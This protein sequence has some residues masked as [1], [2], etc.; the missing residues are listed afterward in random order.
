MTRW[1]YGLTPNEEALACNVGYLR[2]QPYIGS[3]ESNRRFS[4]GDMW[5]I[6]QHT[7]TT[8]SEIAFARMLGMADFSPSVN[9]RKGEPDVG[10][11][12]VRYKFTD[13][14]LKEPSLRFSG[15]VDK[16]TSPYVL[17]TG[18]PEKK[19][20]RSAAN[21]YRTPDFI[22]HGWCYPNEVLRPE[23]ITGE[24]NGK[25]TYSVPISALRSMSEL[26]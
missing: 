24:E 19:I 5:E 14:G 11:W 15:N 10:S 1:N 21:G 22:A 12:E 3:P 18:G 8:M 23:F 25:P 6:W 26:E 4:E 9:T 20:I 7:I 2:Q 13:G 16:L 17:L